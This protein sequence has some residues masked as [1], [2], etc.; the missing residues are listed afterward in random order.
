M[1]S[2]KNNGRIMIIGAGGV[3]TVAAHKCAQVPEVFKEI[4]VAS[5]TLSKCESIKKDIKDRYGREI[6]IAQ[7]DAD[8]VPELTRLIESYRPFLV[9]NLALPYQDLHIMEACLA[10][11]VH[12][13]DTANYEPPDEA[14]FEY[15]WQWAYNDRFREKGIMAVLGSGF[16]PGVTNVFAAYA[17]RHLFDEIHYLDILDCNAGDHGHPFATNFNPEINIREVTQTVRHWQEGRWLKTPPIIEDGSIHFS[18]DYP[19]VGKRES[20]LLYHEELESLV[21]NIK[22]LKRARF[23]MTFSENYLNHL[24]VLKNVGMTRI[25]EVDFEGTKIVP[26]KFLKAL[27]PEPSSLGMR[28]KGKT[29]IGNV[30]TG[31]KDGRTI[32]RYIYNVCDHE[33]AFRETGTQAIAYTTGV[34]AMIGAMMVFTGLWQGA[35]V[36]NIE[37][38]EPDGF[39]DALNR[40]GLPWQVVECPPLPDNF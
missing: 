35:G 6:H 18:F 21:L 38:L 1:D 20:Y 7:V 5:R 27:L 32:T 30:M 24:K 13:I 36:F 14:H 22:G 2:S 40:Y 19:V 31:I 10:T 33:D 11:G 8:N 16:D 29:V 3:A 15:S 17:Q 28:Y 26:I 4:M 9:L 37:Q 34:P 12:Y 39:M 23:W 25:D